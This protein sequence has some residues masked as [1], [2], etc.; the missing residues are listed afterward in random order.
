MTVKDLSDKE[1]LLLLYRDNQHA[2]DEIYR[3]YWNDMFRSAFNLLKDKEACLDIV[4]ELFVWLW[5]HRNNLHIE[6]LRP[7]LL[8]A[9]K[10]K[11]ANYIKKGKIRSSFFDQLKGIEEP[12][13]LLE[14]SLEVKEMMEIIHKFTC[15]LPEKSRKIFLLSRQEHLSNREIAESLNISIKTVENQMTIVLRKLKS[16]LAKL[17]S[18]LLFIF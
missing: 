15:Q 12:Q 18:I 2:F 10:F 16:S 14:D 5:E 17:I 6:S 9:V 4:Q 7:Y 13:H 8:T 11:V 3:R 1:L